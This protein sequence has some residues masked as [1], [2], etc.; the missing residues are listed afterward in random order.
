MSTHEE[1]INAWLRLHLTHGLSLSKALLLLQQFRH[2]EAIFKAPGQ[3]LRA[4]IGDKDLQALQAGPNLKLFQLSQDWLKQKGHWIL[5]LADEDYPQ[6]FLNLPDPPLLLYGLGERALLQQDA[7]AIVG[8]RQ[9]TPY[10]KKIAV[11]F[12]K[13]IAK[14]GF[15]IV[16][17]LALGVDTA[18]H[19]GALAA[20]S[21]IAILGTGIDVVYPAQNKP[22]AQVIAENGVLLTEFPLQTPPKPENFPRRNRLIAALAKAVLVVEAKVKSGSLITARMAA[23]QG[24]DVFAIP[25]SIYAP[26]SAGCHQLIKDGAYVCTVPEDVLFALGVETVKPHKTSKTSD[27]ALFAVGFTPEPIDIIATRLKC[28]PAS[29]LS[30]LLRLEMAG[31][32]L[33][34]PGGRYQRV[35]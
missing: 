22:L 14:S 11:D 5:T 28:D 21:T 23:E 2:P 4:L 9:V 19:Q 6:T 33:A 15:S 8:S 16:S 20:G 30:T 26:T 24:K 18:A 13:M 34:L 32:V 27:P 10:G 1:E 12:A 17:G 3:A 7:V 31:L 25:G 29:A 35:A